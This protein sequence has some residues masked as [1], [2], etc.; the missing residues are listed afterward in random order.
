MC[1]CVRVCVQSL[2]LLDVHF[3]GQTILGP[4]DLSGLQFTDTVIFDSV[5]KKIVAHYTWSRQ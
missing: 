2:Y 1:A 5:R 4:V 3:T